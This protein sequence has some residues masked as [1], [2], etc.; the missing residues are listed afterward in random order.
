MY[1]ATNRIAIPAS[2]SDAV[3][4]A[5]DI[6][7]ARWLRPDPGY[8][9]PPLA[10]AVATLLVARAI[11]EEISNLSAEDRPEAE[12][13]VLK[14]LLSALREAKPFIGAGHDDR[15]KD[16]AI[17]TVSALERLAV[18]LE[19]IGIGPHPAWPD[20]TGWRL[21]NIYYEIDQRWGSYGFPVETVTEWVFWTVCSTLRARCRRSMQ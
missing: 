3:I 6:D 9:E 21:E 19:A 11:G 13:V 5:I 12:D 18:E 2:V 4:H 15:D 10:T 8:I 14:M 20:R 7:T 1:A 16:Y 17:R